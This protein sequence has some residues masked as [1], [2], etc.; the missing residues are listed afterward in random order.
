MSSGSSLRMGMTVC[1]FM[2]RKQRLAFD[3]SAPTEWTTGGSARSACLYR[4]L[5]AAVHAADE[6]V[7]LAREDRVA[8]DQLDAAVRDLRRQAIAITE[9]L[10][11]VSRLP[12]VK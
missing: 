11:V 2:R 6:S 1:S 3:S 8:T 10:V 4:R 12:V 9:H 5:L 7:A